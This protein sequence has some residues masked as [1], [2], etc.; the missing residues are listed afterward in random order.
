MSPERADRIDAT[1]CRPTQCYLV[2]GDVN[3]VE[4]L[5]EASSDAYH[6]D[7]TEGLKKLALKRY[8]NEVDAIIELRAT[9]DEHSSQTLLTGEAVQF[10]H[11]TGLSCFL[12]IAGSELLDIVCDSERQG[13]IGDAAEYERLN[14]SLP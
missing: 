7:T 14:D 12:E 11:R 10:V 3:Y 5:S 13:M 6:V 9:R 2:L 8:G 4:P 1:V